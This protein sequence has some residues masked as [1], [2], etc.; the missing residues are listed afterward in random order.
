MLGS[1][2]STTCLVGVPLDPRHPE[3]GQQARMV[4]APRR[5]AEALL[6][7][8]R[9]AGPLP[10]AGA[11]RASLGP[12]ACHRRAGRGACGIHGII[13]RGGKCGRQRRGRWQGRRALPGLRVLPQRRHPKGGC[14]TATA[15]AAAGV[16]VKPQSIKAPATPHTTRATQGVARV[17]ARHTHTAMAA[18]VHVH[19]VL[20]APRTA[21]GGCLHVVHACGT[22]T[23]AGR[24]LWAA[25]RAAAGQ[26]GRLDARAAA[27][28][29]HRH[30]VRP[31]PLH[32][33]AHMPRHSLPA[34]CWAP[35][36][37]L[38]RLDHACMLALS[39]A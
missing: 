29:E 13:G 27:R 18:C 39:R 23:P 22:A 24:Q 9:P 21:M 25:V 33:R 15:A 19:V 28:G 20:H 1:P 35:T 4:V 7:A 6:N 34:A 37:H 31:R 16:P 5:A 2:H 14:G 8:R 26:H 10:A 32:A 38:H 17:P 11:P 12:R 36:P 3:R 30:A